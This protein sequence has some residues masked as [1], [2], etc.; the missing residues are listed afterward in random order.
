MFLNDTLAGLKNECI[1]RINQVL[2]KRENG[3]V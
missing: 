1:N 3:R 2:V